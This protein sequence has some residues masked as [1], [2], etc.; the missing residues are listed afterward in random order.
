MH[1]LPQSRRIQ[2]EAITVLGL[3]AWTSTCVAIENLSARGTTSGTCSSNFTALGNQ[4]SSGA[5]IYF[6]GSADFT[7]VTSR[8]S[9]L[10]T[11]NIS[12]AVLPATENDVAVTVQYANSIGMPFAAF[13]GM[14]GSIT[15]LG[16]L[17]N[18]I[19]IYLTKLSDIAIASDGSTATIGGGTIAINV[20]NSLWAAGKQAVTGTCECVSLLGPGLGGGHGW[21]Q[22]HHGLVSD[23]WVS[24]NIVLANGTLATF[25]T[26][27]DLWW[28]IKGAGHNF[29]IVTSLTTKIYDIVSPN[30]AI[31]TIIFD[32]DDVEAVY[33]ATNDVLLKNGSQ[34]ADVVNW[35][36]WYNDPTTD[37]TKVRIYPRVSTFLHAH[38]TYMC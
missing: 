18:G 32:G 17:T 15:T 28:A 13:S 2:L 37:A 9:S 31:E 16:K 34:T 24:A 22:G 5:E 19:Q 36:Y 3:W 1:L 20:T 23:Q 4:L 33:Q 14:H 7:T 38:L 8:W 6:P 26:S 29:G 21:L 35:S 30:W 10:D 12:V 27:S 25:D 11:P